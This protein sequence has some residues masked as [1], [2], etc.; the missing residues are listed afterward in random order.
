MPRYRS[1]Q[2]IVSSGLF[3][4]FC[5][6]RKLHTCAGPRTAGRHTVPGTRRW[7]FRTGSRQGTGRGRRPMRPGTAGARE[8]AGA[9]PRRQARPPCPLSSELPLPLTLSVSAPLFSYEQ[10]AG[11]RTRW[12]IVWMW[13]CHV[14]ARHDKRED[15]A[16]RARDLAGRGHVR[17]RLDQGP[18]TSR[19]PVPVAPD[20][21]APRA[22]CHGS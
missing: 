11:T 14:T 15:A 22:W 3:P 18:L 9:R 19:G 5:T 7:R 2:A 13:W 21:E 1:N 20:G 10:P 17:M 16:V 12:L 8:R 6:G 4:C